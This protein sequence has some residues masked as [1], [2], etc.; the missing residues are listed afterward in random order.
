MVS[1]GADSMALLILVADFSDIAPRKVVIHHCHHG[2]ELHAETWCQ[3]VEQ[4]S[5]SRGF[6]FLRHD[7]NLEKGPNFEA[8]ARHARYQSVVGHVKTGDVVMT[9]HNRDDQIETLVM[10]LSQGSGLIGL[11]GIPVSRKFGLGQLIRPLLEIPRIELRNI[12]SARK[13]NYASDP[14]NRDITYHRNFVRFKFLPALNRTSK[15]SETQLIELSRLASDRLSKVMVMLGDRLPVS[16]SLAVAL[17]ENE[18]SIGWQIR[19]FAKSRGLFAPSSAQISEFARQCMGASEDRSPE[20]S[21]GSSAKIRKWNKSLHWVETASQSEVCSAATSRDIHLDP[22]S[23]MTL[24]FSHGQLTLITASVSLDLNILYGVSGGNLRLS[25]TRP[26]QSLKRIAKILNIPP[27][28]RKI[29]PII[30]NDDVMIGWGPIDCRHLGSKF[31]SLNWEWRFVSRQK[32]DISV[33]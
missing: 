21:L 18:R 5:K 32:D 30:A 27:W 1:G 8:R 6:D 17:A 2:I 29:S 26:T 31:D 19:F 3:I 11:T 16:E 24:D 15:T 28:L 33:S 9:A 4:E 23:Q 14:S 25:Q 12:L 22:Y 20:V 7:L 13:V 10:R